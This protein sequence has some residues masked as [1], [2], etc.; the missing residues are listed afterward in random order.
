VI[1]N[2]TPAVTAIFNL[3]PSDRG[4]PLTS[5]TN[6]LD[7]VDLRQE[8]L[9]VLG[10]REVI[11]RRVTTRDGVAHYLM[12]M[13][14]YRTVE[15][16][17][18]GVVLTFFDV[19]KVVEGE[20]LETLVDELNHRIRNMLQVVSSVAGHTL[21]QAASLEEFDTTFNGRL[22]ALA[23]AHELV[24]LGGWSTVLLL[25]LVMKELQPYTAGSDRITRQGP[26]VQL[27]SGMVLS[28]GMVLH[29]MVTNAVKYGA[30]SSDFGHVTV[31]WLAEGSGL[32]ERLVLHWVEAGGPKIGKLPQRRGFG[33]ELIERQLRHNLGGTINTDYAEA[34][35]R[36]TLTLP[37]GII[38]GPDPRVPEENAC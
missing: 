18:D 7:Q 4:R 9:K 19:T 21:R 30:L 5:F 22:R 14:P 3:V 36:I 6:H 17:A 31:T 23:R 33:S 38:A 2:F 1:R 10:E 20:V 27:K 15:G 13:L 11:E 25:D 16:V 29:E 24:S 26:P 34:G 32:A 12:R 28:L 8:L 35:V 37:L